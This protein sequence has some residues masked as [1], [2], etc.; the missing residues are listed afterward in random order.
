MNNTEYLIKEIPIKVN[1]KIKDVL[2]IYGKLQVPRQALLEDYLAVITTN[3]LEEAANAWVYY[4][5]GIQK[6]NVE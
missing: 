5:K 6:R 4:H 3:H 1:K 2:D